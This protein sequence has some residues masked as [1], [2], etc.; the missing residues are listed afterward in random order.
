MKCREQGRE[1]I[2]YE[3]HQRILKIEVKFKRRAV[4]TV[5][6][7]SSRG[8]TPQPPNALPPSMSGLLTRYAASS[9]PAL[10]APAYTRGIG[11]A[12]KVSSSW[13]RGRGCQTATELAPGFLPWLLVHITWL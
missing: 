9:S 3:R 1:R 13:Y 12:I 11:E 8:S 10:R 2:G 5:T 4:V 6:R 7:H